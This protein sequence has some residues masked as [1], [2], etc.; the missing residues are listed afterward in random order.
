MFFSSE[1]VALNGS[2]REERGQLEPVRCQNKRKSLSQLLRSLLLYTPGEKRKGGGKMML[3][4][5]L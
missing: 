4:F 1:R 5:S 3:S 2:L